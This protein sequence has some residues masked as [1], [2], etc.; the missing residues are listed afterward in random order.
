MQKSCQTKLR[1]KK[2]RGVSTFPSGLPLCAYE[3][4]IIY[5]TKSVPNYIPRE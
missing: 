3:K 1:E 2:N 4:Y 5:T